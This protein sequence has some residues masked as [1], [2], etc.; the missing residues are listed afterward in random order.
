MKDAKAL[1]QLLTLQEAVMLKDIH[2]LMGNSERMEVDNKQKVT[3]TLS[4]AFRWN[5]R[6]AGENGQLRA[7]IQK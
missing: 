4:R 7:T 2:K 6:R 5:E 3:E 1:R